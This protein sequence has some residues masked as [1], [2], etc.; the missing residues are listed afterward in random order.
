[1]FAYYVRM[2][3]EMQVSICACK[4]SHVCPET[5]FI[6]DTSMVQS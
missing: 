5:C 2:H 3:A 1:M 6:G 4:C